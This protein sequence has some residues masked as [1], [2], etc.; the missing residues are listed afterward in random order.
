LAVIA[1]L[2]SRPRV[3]PGGVVDESLA[4]DELALERIW[5]QDGIPMKP[6][7]VRWLSA[8]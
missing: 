8:N 6:F 2:T 5:Q 4:Y 7:Q 3:I 1:N